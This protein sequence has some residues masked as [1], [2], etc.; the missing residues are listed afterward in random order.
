MV[1]GLEEI[2][3]GR[4]CIDGREMN[5]V[6]AKD[7]DIAMVFQNYALYPHMTVYGNMAFALK[8]RKVKRR[9]IDRRVRKI[10][11]ILELEPYLKRKPAALSGGQRQR[12]ALGRAMVREP[13]VFL[14]DEPLS[15]LDAKLR[16]AM[17]SEIVRLHRELGAT[18]LYVTHDQTEAMT[19][20]SRIVVLRDGVLQQ[21]DAPRVLY[22]A[23]CNR[24]VAQF[25]GSPQMNLV[26]GALVKRG[27]ALCCR[28]AGRELL[29]DGSTARRLRE[30]PGDVQAGLR[31]EAI[32]LCALG[33]ESGFDAVVETVEPLGSDTYVSVRLGQTGERLTLR[34]EADCPAR[35][36]ERTG[37]QISP[38]MLHFFDP[39]SG[40][41]LL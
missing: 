12:V 10:A 1:A 5:Q 6:A 2:T 24:F 30:A 41:T 23:P 31:P 7:R 33:E 36:G 20:G 29:L 13:K 32:Y 16:T 19:M 14:F 22:N 26:E 27:N 18:F 37:V 28:I 34:A 40:V 17:R 35:P 8:M 15:N 21:A 3:S 4:I 11:E 39:A 25:L 9:E 38:A